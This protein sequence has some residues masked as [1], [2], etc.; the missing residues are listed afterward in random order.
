MEF[1]D[2]FALNSACRD[3]DSELVIISSPQENTFIK[4]MLK[5]DDATGVWFG[6]VL[7]QKDLTFEW[8]NVDGA[9]PMSLTDWGNSNIEIKITRNFVSAIS[10][11]EEEEEEEEE[12]EE[13]KVGRGGGGGDSGGGG[14]GG[15]EKDGTVEVKEDKGDK[16]GEKG[17]AEEG[18]G[19]KEED[20]W[21]EAE[22]EG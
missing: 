13:K 8:G 10:S 15:K 22:K 20:K 12:Q 5:D 18:K 3:V 4:S 6:L 21:E 16:G 7:T 17:K 2:F 19:A 1:E 11:L 9:I 14:R